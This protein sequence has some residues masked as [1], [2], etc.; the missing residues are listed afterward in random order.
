MIV[1]Y[2]YELLMFKEKIKFNF[3]NILKNFRFQL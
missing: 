3:Y 2:R 1:T